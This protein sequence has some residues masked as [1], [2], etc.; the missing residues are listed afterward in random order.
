MKNILLFLGIA[1]ALYWFK[2]REKKPEKVNEL[3]YYAGNFDLL[4][5][6]SI[7]AA[8]AAAAASAAN[9]SPTPSSSLDTYNR[10]TDTYN[11]VTDTIV[12]GEISAPAFT[13]YSKP[14]SSFL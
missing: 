2:N 4:P 1:A 5:T 12:K 10:N 14:K 9:T 6:S 3:E 8:V 7:A 13:S 11:P